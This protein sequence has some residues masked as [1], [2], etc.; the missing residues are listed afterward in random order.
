MGTNFWVTPA[1]GIAEVPAQSELAKA[2]DVAAVDTQ[3]VV[4][5][6]EKVDSG[7]F[8]ATVVVGKRTSRLTGQSGAEAA[9]W[10]VTDAPIR[11]AHLVESPHPCRHGSIPAG[12]P[13]TH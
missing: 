7:A 2:P 6:I 11:T 1:L 12:V 10:A 9:A 8:V 3:A 13:A 5:A 4:F